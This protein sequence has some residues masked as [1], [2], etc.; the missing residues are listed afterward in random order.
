MARFN[1]KAWH[2]GRYFFSE[3]VWSTNPDGTENLV[4]SAS[5]DAY[6]SDPSQFYPTLEAAMAM[7][8]AAGFT[9]DDLNHSL[10]SRAETA[11]A[12]FLACCEGM[13][14]KPAKV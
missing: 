14:A 4:Y 5:L 10:H 1:G 7:A 3:Y 9:G 13:A 12:A 11:T 8:I 2:V 6:A